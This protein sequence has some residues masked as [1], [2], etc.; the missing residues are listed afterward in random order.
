MNVRP[1]INDA[2][3]APAIEY[4]SVKRLQSDVWFS[5]NICECECEC[6]NELI[7]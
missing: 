3:M 7:L 5:I 6:V 1:L 2:Q 4:S